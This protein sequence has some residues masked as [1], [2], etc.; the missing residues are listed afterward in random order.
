MFVRF[1]SKKWITLA[2]FPGIFPSGEQNYRD[3]PLTEVKSD[4]K[5]TRTD[6]QRVLD[7]FKTE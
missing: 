1:G 4:K 5:E 6:F 2:I 7:I 3:V